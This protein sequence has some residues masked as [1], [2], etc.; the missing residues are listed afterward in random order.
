M[1][2]LDFQRGANIV[3]ACDDIFG[4]GNFDWEIVVF[5]RL[6]YVKIVYKDI[7]LYFSCYKYC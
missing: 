1:K 7:K 6:P 5:N 4:F 3:L 2:K